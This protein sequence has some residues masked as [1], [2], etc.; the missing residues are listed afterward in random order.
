MHFSSSEESSNDSSGA[1]GK[2]DDEL[3]VKPVK[4]TPKHAAGGKDAPGLVA[5]IVDL[6]N[7]MGLDEVR[8]REL[9]ALH[10]A[11]KGKIIESMFG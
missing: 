2:E 3:P 5:L 6:C 4:N 7:E 1:D 9:Y 8:V 10:G 11:D